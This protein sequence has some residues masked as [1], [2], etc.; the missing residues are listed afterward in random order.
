MPVATEAML[1]LHVSQSLAVTQGVIY[2]NSI[3]VEV[4]NLVYVQIPVFYSAIGNS[5]VFM[6]AK[7]SSSMKKDNIQ[8]MTFEKLYRKYQYQVCSLYPITL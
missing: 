8:K 7:R 2:G 5:F 3:T 6:I 4:R 1:F